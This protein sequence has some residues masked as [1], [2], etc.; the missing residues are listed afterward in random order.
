MNFFNLL[1]FRCYW[2]SAIHDKIEDKI[3]SRLEQLDK[4]LNMQ[5]YNAYPPI[6]DINDYTKVCQVETTFYIKFSDIVINYKQNQLL[7]KYLL[8]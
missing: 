1:D 3:N 6:L 5:I 4:L 7:N 8:V 2:Y